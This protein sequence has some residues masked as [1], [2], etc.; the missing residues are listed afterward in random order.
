MK[1]IYKVPGSI[2]LLLLICGE[3]KAQQTLFID[4]QEYSCAGSFNIA[5]RTK[6]I[7]NTVA[8][9]GTVR[10]DTAVVKYNTIS[11]GSS[12]IT[13]DAGNVNLSGTANGYLT[14]LWVENNLQAQ[15]TTDST[16][17]FNIHFITNGTGKGK[18]LI[19]FSNIPTAL[20]IDTLDNNGLPVVNQTAAFANGYIITPFIYNFTGAG[21]WDNAANWKD[22]II[23]PAIL[24]AC[25]EILINPSAGNECIL[26]T[27]Q[28]ISAGAKITVAA[29]KKY[30]VAGNI[31]VQ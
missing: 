30:R 18:A 5:I 25:S 28:T 7:R 19:T 20:E 1:L 29:G 11:F 15:S 10:W 27:Q 22:N 31:A 6:S 4:K 12:A 8:L 3:L 17:L 23:P 16:S 21:N 2:V 14:F 26:N 9:Q 24:P 13:L